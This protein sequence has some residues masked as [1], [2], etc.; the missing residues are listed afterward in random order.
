MT[1][2]NYLTELLNEEV[3]NLVNLGV[4]RDD[5]KRVVDYVISNPAQDN[6]NYDHDC[7]IYYLL[8]NE[9]GRYKGS[10]NHA[11]VNLMLRSIKYKFEKIISE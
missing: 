8:F 3:E 2:L 6:Y 4:S 1:N 7:P 5:A 9:D 10:I 11:A